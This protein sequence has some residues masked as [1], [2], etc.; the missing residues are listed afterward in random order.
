MLRAE[1]A[2]QVIAPFLLAKEKNEV[3]GE[4]GELY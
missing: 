2:D 4:S 1:K 3:G